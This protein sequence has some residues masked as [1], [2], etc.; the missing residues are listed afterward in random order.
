V[1]GTAQYISPEQASGAPVGP[2]SDV[3][4]LGIVL[5]E[6]LT[7]SV[8]FSGDSVIAVAMRHVSDPVP[9]AGEL[10][11]AVPASL[12][13]VIARATQKTPEARF[14]TA[15]DMGLAL[16]DALRPTA[17]TGGVVAPTVALGATARTAPTEDPSHTV[18]STPASRSSA[19]LLGRIVLAAL[20]VLG[21]L[22]VVLFLSRPR[23]T[24]RRAVPDPATSPKTSIT[25][26][27]EATPTASVTPAAVVIP[28]VTGRNFS[29][30]AAV[31]RGMGLEVGQQPVTSDAEAGTV[32]D[33]RPHPGEQVSPGTTV[34]LLTSTG[35]PEESGSGAGSPRGKAKGQDKHGHHDKGD[36]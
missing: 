9:A 4:S 36:E 13:A 33:S 26:R 27:G 1:L 22:A 15:A 34:T 19:A 12:D 31:L 24:P 2:A 17:K 7:G 8:P 3:Y 16:R 20:L 25:A 28:D 30:A 29:D 21:V 14:A 6:M 35:P 10:N 23:S 18:S 11:G 5:Y 32:V